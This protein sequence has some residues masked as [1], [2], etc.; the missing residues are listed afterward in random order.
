MFE[1]PGGGGRG[2]PWI[3]KHVSK[4]QVSNIAKPHN[5]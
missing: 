3:F 4:T 5:C 1:N 2:L